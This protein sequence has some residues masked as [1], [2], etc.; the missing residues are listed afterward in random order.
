MSRCLR[1]SVIALTYKNLYSGNSISFISVKRRL[2]VRNNF[3]SRKYL[4]IAYISNCNTDIKLFK[5]FKCINTDDK[6][7]GQFETEY[8]FTHLKKKFPECRLEGSRLFP[9]CQHWDLHPQ[10]TTSDGQTVLWS[11]SQPII[12]PYFSTWQKTCLSLNC[13][14]FTTIMIIRVKLINAHSMSVISYNTSV[15]KIKWK[16]EK[17]P[18]LL[19]LYSPVDMK[20][21]SKSRKFT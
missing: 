13:F 17:S 14:I 7:E 19:A 15:I 12:K 8:K 3:A 9:D 16:I 4:W 6:Y 21:E 10:P 5:N 18:E 11:F 20:L 1:T 2:C